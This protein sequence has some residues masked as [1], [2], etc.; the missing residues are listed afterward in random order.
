MILANCFISADSITNVVFLFSAF[1]LCVLFTE[2]NV[3][4]V[5]LKLINMERTIFPTS[6]NAKTTMSYNSFLDVEKYSYTAD[7]F[8]DIKSSPVSLT[9]MIT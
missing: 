2:V 6:G 4:N 8:H 7:R 3:N 5:F 1:L 9:G